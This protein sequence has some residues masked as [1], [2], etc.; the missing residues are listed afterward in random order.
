MPT[1][2]LIATSIAEIFRAVEK[3][4]DAGL[5]DSAGSRVRR[6]A[7]HFL[8]ETRDLTKL[9]ARRPHSAA[10]RAY[11]Q[12]GET[13]ELRYEHSIPLASYMP[14][15]RAAATDPAVMLLALH[16][17]VRPVLVLESECR[18]LTAAGLASRMPAN[19]MADDCN[20]SY[21]AVGIEVEDLIP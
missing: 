18:K 12:T 6:E 15:L 4:H 9:D 16:K 21:R 1:E 2:L 7:I 14:I 3:L 5:R 8:W 13:S 19:A 10:A 20:A 11:R 17:F